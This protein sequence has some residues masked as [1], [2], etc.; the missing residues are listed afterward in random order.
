MSSVEQTSTKGIS[1][2]F[3]LKTSLVVPSA[4]D[5][6]NLVE[7]SLAMITEHVQFQNTAVT[8]MYT[9]PVCNTTLNQL[10]AEITKRA[11]EPLSETPI[12]QETLNKLM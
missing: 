5:K 4:K 3:P 8:I 9:V 12:L 6:S 1:L 10:Q 11:P 7:T 2:K